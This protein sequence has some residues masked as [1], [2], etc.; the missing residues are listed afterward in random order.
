MGTSTTSRGKLHTY[1]GI[2]PGVGK[3]Y[4]MLREGRAAHRAGRDVVVGYWERKGRPGTVAQLGDLELLA[5]RTVTY[6]GASF[7]ELDVPAVL[8]RCPDLVLVD[9]LAH[10]NTPGSVQEKRW[11]DADEILANG[12]DVFT[13]LNVANIDSLREIVTKI[14]GVH[15]AEP[16][17]DGFVRSGE[18]ELIDLEPAALRRRLAQGLVFPADRADVALSHFFR[19]ANLSALREL[20]QLWL[21]DSVTD[22]SEAFVAA[23]GPCE[24]ARCNVVVVALSASPSDEWLIRYASCTAQLSD[25]GLLGVHVVA[26]DNLDRPPPSSLEEDQQLLREFGGSFQQVKAADPVT[27]LLDAA[28][29]AGAS[30]VVIGLRQRSRLSRRLGSSMV[31]RVLRAAG[32]IPVQVVNVGRPKRESA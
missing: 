10:A 14:T 11:Q 26:D 31:D 15:P 5:T 12:I 2:A 30:Q 4:V 32:D 8:K 13:T 27:G 25:A 29:R 19:F 22:V 9:E 16:V 28:R 18:V 23:H 24:L 17:P 21:D 6:R 3:T 1:L 20:A 7:Q